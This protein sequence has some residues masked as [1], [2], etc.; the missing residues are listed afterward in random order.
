[1]LQAE[2]QPDSP[3]VRT[4][5]LQEHQKRLRSGASQLYDVLRTV[6]YEENE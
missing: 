2:S 3:G 4:P 5:R 6:D 1:M